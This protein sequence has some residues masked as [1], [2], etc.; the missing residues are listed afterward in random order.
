MTWLVFFLDR[1]DPR[2]WAGRYRALCMHEDLL[3][4]AGVDIICLR[5]KEAI[6]L[7]L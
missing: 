6:G 2:G 7:G 3:Y 5:G 4:G 1:Q